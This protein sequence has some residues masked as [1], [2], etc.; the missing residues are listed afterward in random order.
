MTPPGPPAPEDTSEEIAAL[1]TTLH[2]TGE[3]L[4]A[5]TGGEVDGVA[6]RDGKTFLLRGA[7]DRLR[8]IERA[9][10][11][12]V[13]ANLR[14]SESKFRQMADS[15]A[16]VFFLQTSDGSRM[17][18]V[19]PAYER[20][21][22]RSCDS[23]YANS[24]SWTDSIHP[25]DRE[26]ALA[27]FV[28]GQST[29][30]DFEFRILRPDG[31][32]RSINVRGFPMLDAEGTPYRTAGVASDITARKRS[33]ETMR[34]FTAA[35]DALQDAT[36][37]VDR[38]S[39]RFVHA[40]DAAC[41]YLGCERPQLLN[42]EPWETLHISRA[43]LERQ[44]DALIASGEPA[45]PFEIPRSRPDGTPVWAEVRRHAQ[46][47]GDRWTIVTL[48][49][50]VTQRKRAEQNIASLNR[51]YAVLSGI[52]SAIVR[53]RDRAGLF[54]E[55][56]RIAVAE[57]GFIAARITLLDGEGKARLAASSNEDTAQFE[58]LLEA[59]NADPSAP[60]GLV[61]LALR[62]GQVL[63]S[64][65]VAED[66]RIP[67]RA[68]M[69]KGGTFALA[70]LPLVVGKRVAGLVT[71]RSRETGSFNDD[72]VRLLVD[73]TGNLSLA[74]DRIEQQERIDLLAAARTRDEASLR[75]FSGAMDAIEDAIYLVDRSSMKFTYVNDAACRLE[76]RRREEILSSG[77]VGLYLSPGTDLVGTYDA[78]IASG[79]PA[80]PVEALRTNPGGA[81]EWVEIRRHA[82]HS[83]T[84]WTIVT[85]VRDV[86]ERRAAE[87]RITYL[88][89][90]Y[91]ML[92]GINTLIVRA[93][94]REELFGEACRIAVD[95]GGLRIAL[96][97][98]LDRGSMKMVKAGLRAQSDALVDTMEA[99][100]V[101]ADGA[102]TPR[103]KQALEDKRPVVSNDSQRDAAVAFGDKHVEVGIRSMVILP[104]VVSGE[105]VGV[106]ALYSG[107]SDFFHAEELK[108]LSELSGDIAHAIDHIEKRDRLDY[109]AY[110]DELT[111]L[112]NR[113]LFLDR[114]AQYKRSAKA[115]R[116]KLALFLLDLE[117][118][119]NI[120]D[121]LGRPTGDELL[122]KVAEWLTAGVGDANVLARVGA[123]QF[124]IIL[125]RVREDR[126]LAGLIEK[127]LGAFLEHR[128]HLSGSVFRIAAKVGATVYPD[129]GTAA[130]TLLKHAEAALKKA[131]SSGNRYLFYEQKMTASSAGKLTLENQLRRA[132][133]EQEFVLHY[134]PKISLVTQKLTGAEAL[135]RWNDPLTGLVPP[136]KFIPVLEE[137][138]MIHDVGRW[139]LQKAIADYLRWSAA[140]LPAVRIAVNVSPLQLRDRNFINEIRQAV[141]CHPDAPGGLEIEI[142][143]S[144][145][146]EDVK[147]SIASLQAIREMQVTLAI[148]DFGTG[149][150]S[151][152][153]LA[154]LPVDTLKIDRSFVTDMTTG[155]DGLSLVST[156]INLAHALKLKV[157]AEGVETQ[158]QS[159][160]LRLLGCDEMQGFLFSK[161]VPAEIFEQEFLAKPPPA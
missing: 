66:A 50:D 119:R 16:D 126:N 88:N 21:W 142:T 109:L 83:D 57:G 25:A 37:I 105:A 145:I 159:R 22:G 134:Q 123:D 133:D 144:V 76:G 118:F 61:A 148:D 58:R 60:A 127:T 139:A 107:E 31:E 48:I 19:S 75:R 98:L 113:T 1:I 138:G 29:G 143:E 141:G 49:R 71:L 137:T 24:F 45:M 125:P 5:L 101:T 17:L 10:Q 53:I 78:I 74:L 149:F 23:L 100:L 106:L 117:R 135:I 146:M 132:I 30:F 62:T 157:V 150:S 4:E 154:K 69:A 9:K 42:L 32:T 63:V 110:Y 27:S 95:V 116:H 51:V 34:R 18:Y 64:N 33:E 72:E 39:M 161:P 11:E 81:G 15:I 70:L 160:L 128:F 8:L 59:Y 97:G 136:G 13:L 112:A 103:V 153:Y 158:E 26:R 111:G 131:K 89:R 147:N 82:Q 151:L 14:A 47:L 115:G 36:L 68:E 2:E 84:G 152:S 28:E 92:S 40:N 52:N 73:L 85:L 86:T 80:R 77:P 44:Y 20:I 79:H 3:R 130:A 67:L 90:I 155:P 122:K 91:A 87:H 54:R 124:A 94:D 114:L 96:I 156:I 6:D 104:L 12:A 7:Q 121:T 56:C 93:K 41:R 129:D 120:N 55:A 108:L 43:E 102:L 38:E 35:M 46:L 99:I 65:D 140:G